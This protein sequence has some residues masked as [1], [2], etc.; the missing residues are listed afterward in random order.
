MSNYR[1][2]KMPGGC[3]FFTVVTYRRQPLLIHP[4]SRRILR[5]SILETR[6]DHPFVIEAWVL[7][8]EHMHC[9]WSLPPGDSDYS[10]RWSII[11]GRFSKRARELF[12]RPEWLNES[13]AK[14]RESTLWQR[15]FWEHEI[16]DQEDFNRHFDYVHWNPV[17]HGHVTRSADW[18]YST[19]HRYALQGLYPPNWGGNGMDHWSP[20]K[21]AEPP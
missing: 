9:L 2:A 15:R 17:K 19:F 3:Y 21:F 10:T 1:R 5:E 14:H 7:L 12:R 4:E 8:P 6:R 13:K 16:R 20:G 11:K 18:P